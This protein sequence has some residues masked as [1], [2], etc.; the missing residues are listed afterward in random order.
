VSTWR[1]ELLRIWRT[2]RLVVLVG[3]FLILGFGLPLLTY[4]L[5][6]IVRHAG[7]GV[8]IIAPKQTPADAIQG[9]GANAGQLGTLVVAIVAAGTLAIDARP[10]LAA[11][12]RTRVHGGRRLLLPR[13][14]TVTAA[15]V[16]A[17]VLGGLA[18]W[19][20]TEVLLGHVPPGALAGGL[21]LTALWFCFTTSVVA[22]FT[23]VTRSVLGAVGAA[24]ACLLALAFAGSISS[25]LATWVPTRLS[26]S[27][28]DLMRHHTA[29]I[30]HAILVT[31]LTS[32]IALAVAVV[33]LGRREP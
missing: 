18:A 8:T 31:V 7:N 23:T 11:F 27:A 17:L 3:N 29:G 25:A 12:Y 5:P 33:R 19:Y 1:L 32:A 9:F 4:Y 10:A 2:R 20:E 14:A 6:D 26:A 16:G 30:W 21:A 24:I 15:A 28:A 13:Y 22:F